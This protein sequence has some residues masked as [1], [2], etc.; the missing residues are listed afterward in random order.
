MKESRY[1]KPRQWPSPS[2]ADTF[3]G[4][5]KLWDL[6]VTQLGLDMEVMS[7]CNC[8]CGEHGCVSSKGA[9]K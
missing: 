8:S 5:D 3:A 1:Y 4:D 9:W 7:E 2:R 6:A